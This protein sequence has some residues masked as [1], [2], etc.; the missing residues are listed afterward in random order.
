MTRPANSGS[1]STAGSKVD[2]LKGLNQFRRILYNAYISLRVDYSSI[3]ILCQHER[4]INIINKYI[5]NQ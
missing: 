2:V 1:D 4:L 3:K 5:E